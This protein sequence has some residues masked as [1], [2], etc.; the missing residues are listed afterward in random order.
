MVDKQFYKEKKEKQKEE[1]K[2]S[3]TRTVDIRVGAKMQIFHRAGQEK[4]KRFGGT[5]DYQCGAS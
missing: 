3:L 4:Y 1:K 5:E 2:S